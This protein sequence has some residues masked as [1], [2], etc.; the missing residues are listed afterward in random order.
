MP[1]S[2]SQKEREIIIHELRLAAL[3]LM[4]QKGIKKTTVDE[5]VK[6][7]NIPK[8]TFYLFYESK[9]MLLYDAIMEK[10]NQLHKELEKQLLAVKEHL[11]I[12][13]LTDL[14]YE[15]FVSGFDIGIIPLM[16]N[17]DI[18][19]LLRKLPDEVLLEHKTEDDTFF[20]IFKTLI[21]KMSEIKIKD[22]S[23]AFLALFFTV[24]YKREIG[25][26]Y[27]EVLKIL[28][29]GV[30]IQMMEGLK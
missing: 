23:A 19:L 4:T 30:V 28:I 10:H 12:D 16:I 5:L 15:N 7:A 14:L 21:P 17:G 11:T 3:E 13:S 26:N 18:N 22:Y 8:G 20:M 2:Y 1:K 29:R 6:F 24:S 25:D 9:E 27:E